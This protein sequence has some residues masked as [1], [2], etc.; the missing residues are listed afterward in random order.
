M[1]QALLEHTE[2]SDHDGPPFEPH[3]PRPGRQR[4][5]WPLEPPTDPLWKAALEADS[6]NGTPGALAGAWDE[7]GRGQLTLWCGSLGPERAYLPAR[8]C[9]GAG[10]AHRVLR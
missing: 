3:R 9:P 2:S 4:F 6:A 5:D 7:V 1:Q 10:P 8:A